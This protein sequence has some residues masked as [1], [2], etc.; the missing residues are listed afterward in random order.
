MITYKQNAL[1]PC[2]VAPFAFKRMKIALAWGRLA[3]QCVGPKSP[4]DWKPYVDFIWL[5][6]VFSL[7]RE[8]C[9]AMHTTMAF[10]NMFCL[11][12]KIYFWLIEFASADWV[13]SGQLKLIAFV[14]MCLLT[15]T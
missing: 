1:S 6:K 14:D 5:M 11:Q 13:N 7:R 12:C 10:W 3:P 9:V 15:G 4:R 2:F 8:Q